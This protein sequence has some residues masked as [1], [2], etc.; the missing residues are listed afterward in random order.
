MF[1]INNNSQKKNN[2]YAKDFEKIENKYALELSF[3]STTGQQEATATTAS[4]SQSKK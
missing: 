2:S 3:I 4:C 1:N